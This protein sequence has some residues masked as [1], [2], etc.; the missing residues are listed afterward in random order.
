MCLLNVTR[1]IAAATFFAIS[2][3][4]PSAEPP[5][6]WSAVPKILSHIKEPRFADRDFAI[7]NFGAAGDGKTNCKPALEKAIAAC[8]KSGGGRVL[9]PAGEWLV[10]GPIHLKSNVHLHVEKGA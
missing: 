5:T 6:D 9:I 7:T 3:V 4:C 10:R 1:W 2:S 8:T